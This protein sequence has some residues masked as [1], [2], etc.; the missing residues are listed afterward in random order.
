MSLGLVHQFYKAA[1]FKFNLQELNITSVY[2]TYVVS[3]PCFV[4]YTFYLTP[5]PPAQGLIGS[6]SWACRV[7][8][9]IKAITQIAIVN[10]KWLAT[11]IKIKI[12]AFNG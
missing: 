9:L 11:Y 10:S 4:C 3:Y 5:S 8:K 12:K 6:W 7:D 2:Y 1:N